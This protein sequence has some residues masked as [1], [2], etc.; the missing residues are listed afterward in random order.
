MLQAIGISACNRRQKMNQEKAK[1]TVY[2]D[3]ACPKC[4]KDRQ[5][6]EKLAGKA[7]EAVCWMD[8]TG[9]DRKSSCV[10]SV[11]TPARH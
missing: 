8:I 7:G 5:N 1:M 10:K 9:Q 3:G 6:Y 4:V 11:S 2:Y